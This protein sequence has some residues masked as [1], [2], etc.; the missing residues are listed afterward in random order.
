M[1]GFENAKSPFHPLFLER[2]APFEVL[3]F[4]KWQRTENSHDAHLGQAPNRTTP[5]G[6]HLPAFRRM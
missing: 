6:R 4:M 3:R 2:L 1:P 5:A